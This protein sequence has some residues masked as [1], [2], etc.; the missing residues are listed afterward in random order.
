MG[1]SVRSSPSIVVR[2][3]RGGCVPGPTPRCMRIGNSGR[4]SPI[5]ATTTQTTLCEHNIQLSTTAGCINNYMNQKTNYQH[6][7]DADRSRLMIISKFCQLSTLKSGFF[8][9]YSATYMSSS[10]YL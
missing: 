8:L 7:K 10:T 6:Q 9:T 2:E 3:L 4:T 5:I 1:T